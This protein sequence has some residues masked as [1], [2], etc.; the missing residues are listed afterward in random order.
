V[1]LDAK[2]LLQALLEPIVQE[3]ATLDTFARFSWPTLDLA[4]GQSQEATAHSAVRK[5]YS[6]NKFDFPEG[7]QLPKTASWNN[8]ADSVRTKLPQPDSAAGASGVG[9]RVSSTPETADAM[10]E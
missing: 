8:F 10:Q 3:R 7:S 2:L 1:S 6:M 9:H 4:A 5:T